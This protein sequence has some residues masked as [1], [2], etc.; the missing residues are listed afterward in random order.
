MLV[1]HACWLVDAAGSRLGIWGED[2]TGRRPRSGARV[3]VRGYSRTRTRRSGPTSSRSYPLVP[4]DAGHQ[5]ATL[6]LPTAGGGPVSSPELIRDE[7]RTATDDV[8]LE[9]WR[10]PILEVDADLGLALLRELDPEVVWG[11]SVV[12]LAEVAAFATDLV[13]RGRVLP[14]ALTDPPRA[15]WRP[16]LTGPD[17][18]WARVLASSMPAPVAAAGSEH[19]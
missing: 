19:A 3:V 16:V 12:H 1:V 9:P 15:L 13:G 18:A 6:T 10:V 7:T 11:A 17:A 4:A 2:S 5:T 8:R 14:V